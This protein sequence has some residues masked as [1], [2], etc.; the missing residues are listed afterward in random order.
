[1]DFSTV[2]WRWL[3]E[4]GLPFIALIAWPAWK[5]ACRLTRDLVD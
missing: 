5:I 2:D 1:M 3:L 4:V